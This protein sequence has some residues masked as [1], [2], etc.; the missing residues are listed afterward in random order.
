MVKKREEVKV[1]G[2]EDLIKLGKHKIVARKELG[3][4]T[5]FSTMGLI[6]IAFGLVLRVKLI[7]ILGVIVILGQ[8]T[9]FLLDIYNFMR[10]YISNKWNFRFKIII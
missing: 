9:Y 8:S 3:S 5:V 4:R 6:F 2:D 7:M 10:L 1:I